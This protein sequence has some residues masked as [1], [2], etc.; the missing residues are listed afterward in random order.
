MLM[1]DV[2]ARRF[3]K[4]KDQPRGRYEVQ[5]GRR[6][7]KGPWGRDGRKNRKN[8]NCT[9][10]SR[11]IEFR[12]VVDKGEKDKESEKSSDSLPG[13]RGRRRFSEI[14]FGLVFWRN[15]R[16]GMQNLRCR[17][18]IVNFSLDNGKFASSTSCLYLRIISLKGHMIL[19]LLQQ[20][21]LLLWMS[22]LSQSREMACCLKQA[23]ISHVF[24]Y[25]SA[26]DKCWTTNCFEG[27]VIG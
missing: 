14:A 15:E 10:L 24:Q 12:H 27:L 11:D 17:G 6:S 9:V 16:P 1:R 8:P 19:D 5:G 26:L 21:F 2:R 3:L 23:R 7:L 20:Q 25:T 22:Y 13:P 4:F 18:E